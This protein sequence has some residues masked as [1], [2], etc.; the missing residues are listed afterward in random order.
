MMLQ[1][2]ELLGYLGLA[3]VMPLSGALAQAAPQVMVYKSRTC[4][5]CNKWIDHLRAAGFQVE[6]ENVTDVGEYKRKFGVPADLASCHTAVVGD[7]IVEGHVPADDVIRMLRQE[8]E[9]IGIAVPGMPLGSPG[10]E[11]PNP[12]YYET[13]AFNAAGIV[14]VF[15]THDPAAATG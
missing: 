15:A 5:C 12:Q 1:R 10:M 7:Y 2:R 9:I 4:G 6:A 14:Q 11:A 8:P 13:V 3:L